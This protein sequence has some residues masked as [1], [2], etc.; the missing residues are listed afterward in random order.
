MRRRH[1]AR[2]LSMPARLFVALVSLALVSLALA[3]SVWAAGGGGENNLFA[4]DLGNILWTLV[5]FGL[6][7]FVLGKFAWGPILQNLQQRETFIHDAL[8]KAKGDRDAAE[9]K[10]AEYEGIL[11]EAR[12][13]ATAIVE[14][15]RRD[16]Q[17]LRAKI[18]ETA[19]TEADK[20][21]ERAKREIDIATETAKKELYTVSGELATR[22]A[23]K[24]V[25]REL[26][27]ADHQ[28]LIDES[29]SEIQQLGTN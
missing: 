22:I 23:S 16:A 6:V 14:E 1:E 26:A 20:T 8:A 2:K 18:E 25:R 19:R 28:R 24:I 4:G 9:A 7:L 3:P 12:A 5:I 17:V 10:L 13:E 21:L 15:G 29:I 27:D 11:N